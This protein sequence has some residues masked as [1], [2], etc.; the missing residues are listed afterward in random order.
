MRKHHSCSKKRRKVL[1]RKLNNGSLGSCGVCYCYTSNR[2]SCCKQCLC[3]RC[4]LTII[5]NGSNKCPYCRI[6]FI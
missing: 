2:A 5:N 3:T 6:N 4:T 1:H